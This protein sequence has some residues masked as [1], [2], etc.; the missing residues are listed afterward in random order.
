[1]PVLSWLMATL[2]VVSNFGI[3]KEKVKDRKLNNASIFR[4]HSRNI[5]GRIIE[6]VTWPRM[7]QSSITLFLTTKQKSF[8]YVEV[9]VYSSSA[10]IYFSPST[11][12]KIPDDGTAR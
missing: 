8:H 5:F 4:Q 7:R 10:V 6:D 3:L 1:M 2:N 12:A 9:G 11:L